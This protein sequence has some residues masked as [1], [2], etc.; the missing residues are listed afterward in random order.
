MIED[1]DAET[2]ESSIVQNQ[3]SLTYWTN[4]DTWIDW[5]TL[6]FWVAGIGMVAVGMVGAANTSTEDEM[7]DGPATAEEEAPAEPGE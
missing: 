2:M 3:D 5:V 6:L 7:K 4:F 1:D